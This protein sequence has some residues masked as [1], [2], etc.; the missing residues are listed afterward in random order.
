MPVVAA[1]ELV[2]GLPLGVVEHSRART[3]TDGEFGLLTSLTWTIGPMHVDDEHMKSTPFGRRILGGPIVAAIV[4]GIWYTS[5]WED[6]RR[7]YGVV[8]VAALGLEARNR[9]PVFPNDTLRVETTLV[10]ARA[11]RSRP[12]RGVLVFE[13]KAFNQRGELV[14]EMRRSLMFE[15]PAKALD[16]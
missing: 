12:G 11:S 5:C 14:I 2:A 1:D 3:I 8:P 10:Q 9:S 6:F 4:S 15:R 7:T 16:P 13:D